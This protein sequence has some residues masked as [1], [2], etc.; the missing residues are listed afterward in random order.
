MTM[1]ESNVCVKDFNVRSL[2][3]DDDSKIYYSNS[4]NHKKR[5]IIKLSTDDFEKK[6]GIISSD[7]PK[8]PVTPQETGSVKWRPPVLEKVTY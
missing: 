6:C 5:N 7:G 1:E 4:S 8:D 2:T 3:I